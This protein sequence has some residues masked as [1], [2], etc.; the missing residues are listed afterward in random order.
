VQKFW[1]DQLYPF[2]AADSARFQLTTRI[3]NFGG[4]P[5]KNFIK[6]EI[7]EIWII[8]Q[9]PFHLPNLPLRLSVSARD[10]FQLAPA[11]LKARG[12]QRNAKETESYQ[13]AGEAVAV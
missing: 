1:H 10:K 3:P 4:E 9:A 2:K 11:S 7:W 13:A 12:T 8:S 5:P 6:C